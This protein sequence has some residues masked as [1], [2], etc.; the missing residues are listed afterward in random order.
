MPRRVVTEFPGGCRIGVHDLSQSNI[1]GTGV[2][3][4]GMVTR[5]EGITGFVEECNH[6]VVSIVGLD[7]D[8]VDALIIGDPSN[9]SRDWSAPPIILNTPAAI[10]GTTVT[11]RAEC[12]DD[13]ECF[14][15]RRIFNFPC[16]N[17]PAV[18]GDVDPDGECVGD[19]R[20]VSFT[21]NFDPPLPVGSSVAI[22]WSYD[23]GIENETIHV[24][25]S[26]LASHQHTHSYPPGTFNP[27]ANVTV[28]L[29]GDA[30]DPV[31]IEFGPLAVQGGCGDVLPCPM[32]TL[33]AIQVQGCAPESP[34]AVF[35]AVV[36]PAP[37]AVPAPQY[38]W[39]LT[40]PDGQEFTRTTAEPAADT[41]DIWILT[42]TNNAIDQINLNTPGA[43]A[44]TVAADIANT[45]AGCSADATRTFSVEACPECPVVLIDEPE[46]TGC[47]PG[48]ATVVFNA[49]VDPAGTP[50]SAYEWEVGFSPSG[51][52]TRT[53]IT[54][55]A[56][57]ED[58][59]DLSDG[60]SGSIRG[61]LTTIDA[62]S[63]RA[64]VENLP[65]TCS[66]P[67]NSRQFAIPA[68]EEEPNGNGG[69]SAIDLC[70][71]WFWINVGAMV[72]TG[73][74]ILVTFCMIDAVVWTAVAAVGSGGTLAA[75]WAA[76]TAVEVAMLIIALILAIATL[77]SFVLWIIFCA[78]GHLGTDAC[79]LLAILISILTVLDA[80]AV[81]LAVIFA[82]SVPPLVGC[83]V[84][85]FIDF[86]WFGILAGLAWWVGVALGCS[87]ESP[88]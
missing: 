52:A 40:T 27:A 23:P 56:S 12:A 4:N 50:V 31:G 69:G 8:P 9:Y 3:S 63:V 81:V 85:A 62:V 44:I 47:V 15:E 35:N 7:A 41:R 13:A 70:L 84:G 65:E 83:A 26:A 32:L 86:A 37:P 66:Q 18:T 68:C 54:P 67:T 73:I 2:D 16:S 53:T 43:Y 60:S 42:E 51:S 30:C 55:Q 71:V 79:P 76:L 25:A 28:T 77:V 46:V 88:E 29:D 24:Q 80:L 57:S 19:E 75:V 39:E 20:Q 72:G 59:W 6:V 38:H 17:C 36:E 11:I 1:R 64:V 82:L 74:F 87:L 5:I 10:C 34:F 14:D 49:S 22:F 48:Q 45:P 78:F 21:L 58:N 33:E 61:R